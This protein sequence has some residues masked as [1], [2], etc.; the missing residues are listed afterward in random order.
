VAVDVKAAETFATGVIRLYVPPTVKEAELKAYLNDIGREM[1]H[2]EGFTS[3]KIVEMPEDQGKMLLVLL[4]FSGPTVE[5]AYAR[6]KRWSDSDELASYLRVAQGL[7]LQVE[8]ADYL[9][10]SVG[11]VDVPRFAKK[12]NPGPPPKWK[13]AIVV[14]FWVFACVT[15]HGVAGTGAAI[16]GALHNEPFSLLVVLAVVVPAVT[17]WALP[18]TLSFPVVSKWASR[19]RERD[20]S[21]DRRESCVDDVMAVLEDGFGLFAPDDSAKRQ[22]AKVERRLAATERRLDYVERRLELSEA[23][24]VASAKKEEEP[25]FVIQKGTDEETLAEEG[26]VAVAVRHYVRWGLEKEFEA[27]VQEI[28]AAMRAHCGGGFLGNDVFRDG[29]AYVGLFRFATI[30]Q[31]ESWRDSDA[32]HRLCRRLEPLVEASS[33]YAPLGTGL[34]IVAAPVTEDDTQTR[35]ERNFLGE[36]LFAEHKNTEG[37]HDEKAPS[38]ALYKVTVLITVGLFLVAFVINS[39]LAAPLTSGLPH[40]LLGVLV[41]T[42]CTVLGNTYF[43][44]PL[45]TFF[46]GHWLTQTPAVPALGAS[47]WR[48]YLVHGSQS[49]VGNATALFSYFAVTLVLAAFV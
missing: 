34:R 45:M 20:A 47:A 49:R 23:T 44:A 36:L 28:S 25:D 10:T 16:G 32:R 31:L 35:A 17:Y 9:K 41:T 24:A 7:G 11:T 8:G 12:S 13:M 30:A 2:F 29:T 39:H 4:K 19:R 37:Q 33:S 3:R 18:L 15:I 22:L 21:H 6:M 27:W 43:G 5:D 46:F 1:R 48:K 14:E 40:P 42:A 38:P 26:G